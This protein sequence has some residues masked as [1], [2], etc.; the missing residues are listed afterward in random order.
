MAK[1][2]SMQEVEILRFFE[3][4]QLERVLPVFNIVSHKM[5]ERMHERGNTGQAERST[6]A[7]K[8][9]RRKTEAISSEPTAES[10]SPL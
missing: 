5:R 8:Q 1:N 10:E 4:G 9:R 2:T 7:S 3:T 6:G